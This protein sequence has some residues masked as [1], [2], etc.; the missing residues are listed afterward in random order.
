MDRVLINPSIVTGIAD[1]VREKTK[2]SGPIMVSELPDAIRGIK[3]GSGEN[4]KDV[5]EAISGV[6]TDDDT[7][8]ANAIAEGATDAPSEQTWNGTRQT[9]GGAGIK[10]SVAFVDKVKGN[11]LKVVQKVASGSAELDRDTAR[12]KNLYFENAGKIGTKYFIVAEIS[13]CVRIDDSS[14]LNVQI[15]GAYFP[16][17]P[18]RNGRVYA[19]CNSLTTNTSRQMY[20]YI[21]TSSPSGTKATIS[22]IM[23]FDL[24]AMGMEDVTTASDFAKRM[25]YPSIEAVPYIPYTEGEVTPMKAE[26]I[27]S[28]G[29][30]ASTLDTFPLPISSILHNGQPLFP[31]GLNG[32]GS[33][34]DEVDFAR[35]RAVKRIGVADLGTLNWAATYYERF[36]SYIADNSILDAASAKGG[37]INALSP[38]FLSSSWIVLASLGADMAISAHDSNIGVNSV[39][40]RDTSHTTLAAFVESVRGIPLYYELAEP[41]VVSFPPQKAYY[42]VEN[43]GS[44]SIIAEGKTAPVTAEIGYRGITEAMA[45]NLL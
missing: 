9:A 17:F 10:D 34:K 43:G 30:D 13:N 25:G 14:Q 6:V 16:I 27:V 26:A 38:K 37:G 4:V 20:W 23:L 31:D 11:S 21:S 32:V 44:E 22:N 18:V 1:A 5:V 8:L 36:Q 12:T 28:K 15:E 3:G 33:V 19:L 40:V 35:G 41:V 2:T 45:L 42:K 29:A 39:V 7:I 24:T